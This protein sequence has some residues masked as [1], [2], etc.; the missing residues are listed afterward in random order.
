[1]LPARCCPPASLSPEHPQNATTTI[2]T[3]TSV[4]Q[5]RPARTFPEILLCMLAPTIFI[6]RRRRLASSKTASTILSIT[7]LTAV[8]LAATGCGSNIPPLRYALSGNY[9][10]QVTASSTTGIPYSQTVTLNLTIK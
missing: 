9:Q 10:F 8:L 4:S 2:T 7:I 1:M 6:L 5:T 3:V